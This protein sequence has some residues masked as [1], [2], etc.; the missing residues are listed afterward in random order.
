MRPT[1]QRAI[2]GFGW[3]RIES[4]A[5]RGPFRRIARR[6]AQFPG[7]GACTARPAAISGGCASIAQ[8]VEHLICNQGVG[9]SSPSGGTI[10]E[11]VWLFPGH[12]SWWGVGE[13]R[14]VRALVECAG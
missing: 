11:P 4:W 5:G 13:P 10:F 8:L 9:G 2:S 1:A 6:A 14:V 7:S 12:L 3:L